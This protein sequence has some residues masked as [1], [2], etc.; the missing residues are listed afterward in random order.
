MPPVK[1]LARARGG[2]QL[3]FLGSDVKTWHGHCAR[4]TRTTCAQPG[5]TAN[6][7][8]E[9]S[10]GRWSA[11]DPGLVDPQHQPVTSTILYTL[12]TLQYSTLHCIILYYIILY[13]IMFCY[14]LLYIILYY[15]I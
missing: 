7:A 11:V 12:I 15:I 2:V 4:M 8:Q 14:I 3:R 1:F 6:M 5:A 13:C 10:A 9:N